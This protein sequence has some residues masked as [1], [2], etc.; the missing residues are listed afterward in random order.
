[1]RK[2]FKT[3]IYYYFLQPFFFHSLQS[4]PPLH[5]SEIYYFLSLNL[6][7]MVSG[8]LPSSSVSKWIRLTRGS[9]LILNSLFNFFTFMVPSCHRVHNLS[10]LDHLLVYPWRYRNNNNENADV[11]YFAMY[12]QWPLVP[13]IAFLQFL[14]LPLRN[15]PQRF[16]KLSAGIQFIS[17]F[18]IYWVREQGSKGSIDD[19][20]NDHVVEWAKKYHPFNKSMHVV[21]YKL[22]ELRSRGIISS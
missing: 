3:F 16:W 21:P 1:M 2:E 20:D 7:V 18:W 13:L 14:H 12:S 22:R 11:D 17:V 9:L 6:T 19:D 5:L 8:G 4:H 10:S 15:I